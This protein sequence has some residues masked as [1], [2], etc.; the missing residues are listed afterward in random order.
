MSTPTLYEWIGGIENLK[1]LTTEFYKRVA[2]DKQLRDIFAG[3]DADHP[4]HVAYFIGEVFGGPDEYSKRFGGHPSMIRHHLNK[5]LTESQRRQW[6]N[7]LLDTYTDLQLPGD[8][9]FASALVSYLEWGSRL[10]VIN[11][12][13][14][15]EVDENAPMPKW[16]WGETG[17]P[18]IAQD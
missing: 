11:S 18:Y 3:M 14:G 16:G 10:A 8:P 1:M 4:A 12:D 7:L 9:E 13:P 17:G 6:I 2:K 5:R 15:A